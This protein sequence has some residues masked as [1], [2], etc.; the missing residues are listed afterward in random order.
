MYEERIYL[1][2][3]H[4]ILLCKACNNMRIFMTNILYGEAMKMGGNKNDE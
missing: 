2:I 1:P 4:R 3:V